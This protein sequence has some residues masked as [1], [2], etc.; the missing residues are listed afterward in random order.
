M[1]VTAASG[2]HRRRSVVVSTIGITQ[3][4]AWGST[5]YL[6]AVFADPISAEL[7]L[8]RV[9][10]FGIFSGALLLS[11]LLGPLAGRT[12]D[13]Y[14]GRDVLAATSLVF[15]TGLA[16]LSIASNATGLAVAWVILGVGMGFGLY[17]AAFATVAGLYGRHARNAITGI[18][19]FAGFASTVGWP[20]SA[21][22]IDHFGWRGAC[23]AWAALHLLIGLPLNRL[24]VPKA[25]L[26][27]PEKAPE[28]AAASGVPWTMIV[29]AGVFGA[30]WFVSTAFAAHLPRLLEAMGA[31]PALAI[32]AGSFI[33]P[34]QVAARLFEFSLLRRMSPLISARLATGLHP[35]G[36]TLLAIFG[37]VAAIPFVLLHGGG[38]GML[39]IA[40]GT[41]PLALFGPAGYGLRTGLLAAPARIL[42]G[43]APLLFGIV[44]DR[45]GPLAALLLSG[46]LTS[47]SFL[48]LFALS[49][50]APFY[51]GV[52]KSG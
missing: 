2:L 48:A 29:L 41:L 44:L 25:Q 51:R 18:T 28:H 22:F 47:A 15:A 45:G 33:G 50:K 8:P 13:R 42:Q 43:G 21:L 31:T 26:H 30:T 23:L 46:T 36:A 9:W 39:T 34:A 24:L 11:G 52:P 7:H 20:A 14:G 1:S 19:L 17:E 40:R 12:I 38:N 37:P 4:L 16:L 6:T 10:F 3:T 27:P 35:I 32:T 49:A 5:Y